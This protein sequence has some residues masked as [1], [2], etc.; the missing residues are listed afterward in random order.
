MLAPLGRGGRRHCRQAAAVFS[1]RLSQWQAGQF[2]A[3]A[4]SYLAQSLQSC[5]S[6]LDLSDD[7]ELPDSVRRAVLRAVGDGAL[8]K[9]SRILSETLFAL[10]NDCQSALRSL[11]PSAAPPATTPDSAPLGE[12]FTIDDVLDALRTFAPGSAGGYSGLMA[13]HLI[14]NEGPEHLQML[15][16]LANLCSSFAWGRLPDDACALLASARLIPLGKK[17]GGVRP[18]AVGET[19]RRLAGK[20]LVAR[21][22]S[23]LAQQ[24]HPFQLCLGSRADPK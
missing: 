11:H 16:S 13:A 12:D 7:S 23:N 8:S 5:F 9:A 14:G 17:D 22:Q 3:L 6:R 10:P 2:H 4:S 19:I 1:G 24:F 21:Y 20:M 18:I 15:Q